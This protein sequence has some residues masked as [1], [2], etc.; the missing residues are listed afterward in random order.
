MQMY[1]DWAKVNFFN[2]QAMKRY[3]KIIDSWQEFVEIGRA[4]ISKDRLS[5]KE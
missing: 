5:F 4:K 2:P 3:K 1:I